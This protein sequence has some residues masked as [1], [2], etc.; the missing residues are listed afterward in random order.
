M[1]M[2]NKVVS[3]VGCA[4]VLV[5]S[6]GAAIADEANT[7]GQPHIGPAPR[8]LPKPTHPNYPLE[9]GSPSCC[10]SPNTWQVQHSGGILKEPPKSFWVC[11]PVPTPPK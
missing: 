8:C 10:P 11:A 9:A 4:A 6:Q 1:P 3:I 2:S 5:M 7:T